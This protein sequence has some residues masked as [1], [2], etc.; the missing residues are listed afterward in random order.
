MRRGSGAWWVVP[1]GTTNR[2]SFLEGVLTPEVLLAKA[3]LKRKIYV[4]AE[5]VAEKVPLIVIPNEVRNLSFL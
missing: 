1:S 4:A 5:Q 3:T 2:L